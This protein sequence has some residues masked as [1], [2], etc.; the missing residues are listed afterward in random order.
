MRSVVT[1]FSKKPK[2]EEVPTAG[3]EHDYS[4]HLPSKLYLFLREKNLLN[5]QPKK[6]HSM[7]DL[8]AI[9]TV[10]VTSKKAHT[11]IEIVTEKEGH[12][13]IHQHFYCKQFL[14]K[15]KWLYNRIY[16]KIEYTG[17]ERKNNNPRHVASLVMELGFLTNE[18]ITP[19]TKIKIP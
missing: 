1:F 9:T 2:K 6:F 13:Q 7:R 5:G 17:A 8:V 19:V 4:K 10:C 16:E 15:Q 11:L 14:V 18:V 3:D 12:K